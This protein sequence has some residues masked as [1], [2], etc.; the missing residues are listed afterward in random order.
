M[1]ATN[2]TMIQSAI[3]FSISSIIALHMACP[4]NVTIIQY[5]DIHY[6]IVHGLSNQCYYDSISRYPFLQVTLRDSNSEYCSKT[7]LGSMVHGNSGT[8]RWW[9][10]Q[11]SNDTKIITINPRVMKETLKEIH[12][13]RF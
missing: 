5:Q 1:G 3:T 8:L 2:V 13:I 10:Q 7:V 4:A 11:S 6:C 9:S 12:Q